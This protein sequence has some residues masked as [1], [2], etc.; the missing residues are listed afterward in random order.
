MGTAARWLV[1]IALWMTLA[2]SV[3][4]KAMPTPGVVQ[5][6]TG[7]D[8]FYDTY[9]GYGRLSRT[10]NG[11]ATGHTFVGGEWKGSWTSVTANGGMYVWDGTRWVAMYW[12]STDGL[13]T[14][15]SVYSG[16]SLVYR[17][18]LIFYTDGSYGMVEVYPHNF[19][20]M[21]PV[22]AATTTATIFSGYQGS[23][24]FGAMYSAP[25]VSP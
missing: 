5:A 10:V 25:Y 24:M 23:Q 2:P 1:V 3:G 9:N 15:A 14:Y 4:L 6:S 19:G 8:W 7:E 21:D 12:L 20:S 17:V 13:S 11:V 18:K 22:T 16:G